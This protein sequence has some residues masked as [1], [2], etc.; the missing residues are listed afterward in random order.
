MPPSSWHSFSR[1]NYSV[2]GVLLAPFL[3]KYNYRRVNSMLDYA[4]WNGT[5]RLTAI[6]QVTVAANA[7]LRAAADREAGCKVHVNFK[8]RRGLREYGG[9]STYMRLHGN[10]RLRFYIEYI[11]MYLTGTTEHNSSHIKGV[12]PCRSSA[13]KQNAYTYAV[14]TDPATNETHCYRT[15]VHLTRVDSRHLVSTDITSPARSI[16]RGQSLCTTLMTCSYSS[17]RIRSSST[18][19]WR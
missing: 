19:S 2:P 9:K 7:L 13:K 10:E 5:R 12:A 6:S 17:L 11:S 16:R 18:S 8:S 3:A 15:P 4:G 1:L 14:F